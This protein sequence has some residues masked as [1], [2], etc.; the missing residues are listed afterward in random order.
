MP[1]IP[2]EDQD[3]ITKIALYV[4]GTI[5]GIGAKLASMH[6]VKPVTIKDVIINSS[7]AFAAAYLV[8]ALLVETGHTHLA[9]ISSVLCGRFADDVLSLAWKALKSFLKTTSDDLNKPG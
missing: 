9:T 5:L 4:L 7:V 1:G 8:Y 3:F 6:R 2:P